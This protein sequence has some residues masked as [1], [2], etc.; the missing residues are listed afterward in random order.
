MA[1]T[2]LVVLF[3]ELE[4]VIGALRRDH[5]GDGARGMPPHATL[6]YPFADA[7]DV[8]ERRA[9]VGAALSR[10]APF[11]VRFAETARFPDVVYVKPEPSE[12][13]VAMTRTLMRAF[14]EFPP[15]GGRVAGIV[16]HV[17][18]ANGDEALLD[19]VEAEVAPKLKLG[20]T[21]RVERAWL[22]EDTPA[23]WRRHTPFP[24]ERRTI[25]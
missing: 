8:A 1:E 13:F 3:P 4:P 23:G 20:L 21:A 14:P 7:A 18:V 6:I 2:A 16:P 22:V 11:E 17:T 24:L 19:R 25:G 12:P 15:Y 9:T 5:T 10:F